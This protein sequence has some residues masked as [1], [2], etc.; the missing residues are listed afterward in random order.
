MN[1]HR[2]AAGILALGLLSGPVVAAVADAGEPPEPA[3]RTP[4]PALAPQSQP[5]P[6]V[7]LRPS[8]ERGRTGRITP[9]AGAERLQVPA[10]V[11][12][13]CAPWIEAGLRNGGGKAVYADLFA[14]IKPPL[15]ASR[16]MIS[17][18]LPA[19]YELGVK[20]L[21]G[22]P[23]EAPLGEYP[24]TLRTGSESLTVP[25]TVV[26]LAG[27]DNGGNVALRRTVTASS[28]HTGGNY[29]ACSVVDGDRSSDG[30]AGGNGW[31]DATSRTWP[32]TLDITLG[33]ERTLSRVDLYT[34]DT[35]R[36]P[37][38]TYGLRDWDVQV[39]T[40][41]QWQT[42]AEVRGNTSGV[43]RSD[44]APVSADAVRILTRASN[45]ANDFSR[46]IEVEAY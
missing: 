23:P 45:G 17:S 35:A 21:I 15:T 18:Y 5:E 13:A 39:R 1:R 37:A 10:G 31:N 11:D 30:W 14:E 40:G 12:P 22:I 46:V 26:D 6:Q 8:R 32:D 25:I 24:L 42:V 4:E 43:V 33:Q 34:I 3:V 7:R 27:L 29:P 44:F 16:P 28:A 20:L 9:V 41:G 38:S 19:G 2:L 36:Y